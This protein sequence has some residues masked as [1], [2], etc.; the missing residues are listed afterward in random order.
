[1]LHLLLDWEYPH[2]SRQCGDQVPSD[3]IRKVL[4]LGVATHI[5]EW[6]NGN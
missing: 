1:M 4:L 3:P 2:W 6:Q 5:R